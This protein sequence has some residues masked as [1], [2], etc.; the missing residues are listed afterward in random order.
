MADLVV[1]PIGRYIIGK[2]V[3][4]D[5]QIIKQKFRKNDK[6]VYDGYG[7]VVLPK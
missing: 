4:E 3:Q 6:G 7:L 1:S 5:F 2:K